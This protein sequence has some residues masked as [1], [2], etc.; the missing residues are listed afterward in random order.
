MSTIKKI[1]ENKSQILEGI[2]NRIIKDKFVEEVSAERMSICDKCPSKG[3]ECAIP[4]TGPCCNECGC[5]LNF[6][7]RSL[8][9]ECPLDKWSALLTDEE[10]DKLEN[11][12][13]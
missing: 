7:T 8:S 5:S 4:G 6:K 1:W 12:N 3:N 13:E 10:E 11:L 9:S 2:T